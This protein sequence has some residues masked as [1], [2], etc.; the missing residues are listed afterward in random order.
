MATYVGGS[1]KA[2]IFPFFHKSPLDSRPLSS[3]VRGDC[4]LKQ[5]AYVAS[6][7]CQDDVTKAEECNC[8]QTASFR[9]VHSSLKDE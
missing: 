8:F 1:L 3:R 5:P 9:Q 2:N 4:H 7:E 6:T